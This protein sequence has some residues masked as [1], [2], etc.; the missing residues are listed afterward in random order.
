MEQLKNMIANGKAKEVP[1]KV[2]ELLKAGK[3]PDVIMKNAMIAAMDEVGELFQKGELYLPEMLMAAQ[4]MKAGLGIIKPKIVQS[5]LKPIGKVI[6]GTVRGDLHDI[7]KNLVAMALEGA[8]FEVID[9]GMD[10]PPDK[11]VEAIKTNNPQV[12]GISAML[13]TTMLS[14][15]ETIEA[16]KSAGLRDKVKIM[17]GGAPVRKQFAD[18]I[19]ADFYG[20]DSISGKNFAREVV[21]KEV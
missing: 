1:K 21:S 7:G 12:V 14:M 20:P 16:I 11:F 19:G 15:K 5:G 17:I 9:L 6:V 13:S 3:K 8:G 18:D 10:V 4:A 2:E